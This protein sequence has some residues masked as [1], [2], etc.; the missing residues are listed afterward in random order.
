M[1]TIQPR[2]GK[3]LP[4]R[5]EDA[6]GIQLLAIAACLGINRQLKKFRR[7]IPVVAEKPNVDIWSVCEVIKEKRAVFGW[8][9]P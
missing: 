8:Y 2:G 3:V 9:P 7:D 5:W 4:L 6:T 1:R